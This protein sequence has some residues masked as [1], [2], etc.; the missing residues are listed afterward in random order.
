MIL[1]ISGANDAFRSIDETGCPDQ[2]R[3]T[4]TEDRFFAF[5]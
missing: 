4:K 2:P 1:F 3:T 5:F